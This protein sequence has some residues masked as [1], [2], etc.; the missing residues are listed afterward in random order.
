MQLNEFNA[1]VDTLLKKKGMM[2][3]KKSKVIIKSFYEHFLAQAWI[4]HCW[5]GD[6]DKM[7]D[8]LLDDKNLLAGDQFNKNFIKPL[9]ELMSPKLTANKTWTALINSLITFK[10]ERIGAGEFYFPFVIKDWE[11]QKDGGTSDGYVAGGKREIKFG[12]ASLKPIANAS[13]RII[14]H[15]VATIFQGNRPGPE[16]ETKTSNGQSFDR[17]IKWFNTQKN[18]RQILL[19]FFTQLYPGRDVESMCKDLETATTCKAFYKIVGSNVLKWYKDIDGFDSLVI[20]DLKKMKVA[21]IADVNNL[22][23]FT[24]LK[25]SWATK[26][27][28]NKGNSSGDIRQVA[29]GYVNISM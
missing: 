25:F 18:K 7:I 21:N 13:H 23:I 27:G 24:T 29:D 2:P 16:K 22:E 20:I 8:L 17:W 1:K 14:D 9:S 6:G 5:Y 4:N 19:D 28:S 15:L 11:F 26:R 10:G 3:G 12:G